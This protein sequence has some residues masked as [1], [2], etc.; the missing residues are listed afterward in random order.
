MFDDR[1]MTLQQINARPVFC[2]TDTEYFVRVGSVKISEESKGSS[3]R[4]KVTSVHIHPDYDERQHN[5]DVALLILDRSAMSERHW[6]PFVCLPNRAAEPSTGQAIVLGWG[7]NTFGECDG[8][9]V[10][11]K[12]FNGELRRLFELPKL[13]TFSKYP[14]FT[15]TG[16]LFIILKFQNRIKKTVKECFST[17]V[18]Q[19]STRFL[20]GWRHTSYYLQVEQPV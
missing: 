20:E 15:L 2:S 11:S 10:L 5:A 14:V 3:V 16:M 19:S 18:I 1:S 7:H 9:S 8:S 17:S 4:R 13:Y 6:P 12:E